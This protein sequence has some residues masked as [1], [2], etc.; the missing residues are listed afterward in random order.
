MYSDIFY[1]TKEGFK[2]DR[3]MMTI[4]YLIVMIVVPFILYYTDFA[5]VVAT[6]DQWK[7]IGNVNAAFIIMGVTEF[8]FGIYFGLKAQNPYIYYGI[9]VCSFIIKTILFI[10][11]SI[12]IYFFNAFG[13]IFIAG[14]V[15]FF[16]YRYVMALNAF[17]GI[18]F[19]PT[20]L[21]FATYFGIQIG[22]LIKNKRKEKELERRLNASSNR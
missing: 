6:Y 14:H 2:R 11:S 17:N 19:I 5:I 20:M 10:L 16:L 7:A 8:I 1:E 4:A 12:I 13:I 9:I 3:K 21:C 18:F 15:E 22:L